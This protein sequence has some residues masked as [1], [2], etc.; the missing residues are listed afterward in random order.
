[1]AIYKLFFN[2]VFHYVLFLII[3]YKKVE[4]EIGKS[5]QSGIKE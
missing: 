4:I 3:Y 2:Y 5:H 1:L